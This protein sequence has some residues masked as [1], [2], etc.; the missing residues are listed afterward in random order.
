M[1]A[2]D[3]N[4]L[5]YAHRE[6]CEFH[7]KALK[8]L[9]KLAQSM[10]PWAIPWPCV[11]EFLA[12]TTHSKIFMPPSPLPSALSAIGVWI[13]SQSCR[14]LGEGPG[15]FEIL[16]PLLLKSKTTGPKVHDARIA[17]ICLHHGV[18]E[19]WSVDRDFSRFTS[20]RTRNPLAE[21]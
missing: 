17:A 14:M 18:K 21:A 7:D 20:L 2:V 6:D 16:M 1:I 11:H 19:L 5:I 3:T 8:V 12:I 4:L 15:Y 13:G 9:M 10:E